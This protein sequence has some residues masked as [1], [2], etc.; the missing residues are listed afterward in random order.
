MKHA[1][2]YR[3]FV[4]QTNALSAAKLPSVHANTDAL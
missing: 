2:R 4:G 1:A 3:G